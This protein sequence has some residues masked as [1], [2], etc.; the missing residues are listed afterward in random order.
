ML[1]DDQ[2]DQPE[3][4]FEENAASEDMETETDPAEEKSGFAER[5]RIPY[6]GALMKAEFSRSQDR[7]P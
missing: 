7:E 4:A 5:R 1:P 2:E 3:A 6:P